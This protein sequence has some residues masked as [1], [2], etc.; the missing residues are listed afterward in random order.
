MKKHI[1]IQIPAYRDKELSKTVMDL[2]KRAKHPERLRVAIAWQH[3]RKE[4]LHK[5]V[6]AYDNVEILDIDYQDS[7][8]CNWA[9]NLLQK[10]WNGEE[11]TLFL[12]SHHRF[13]KDWD[14][15]LIAMYESL[16]S[17]GYKKPLITAY[18]PAYDPENDPEARMKYPLKIYP[19]ERDKGL[20]TKLT[21]YPIPNWK[22]LKKPFE[23]QYISLHFLFARG[24]FNKEIVFDPD[25]YF[26]GDEVLTSVRAYTH[27]Y[28]LFHP[29]VIIGWHLYDRKTRT[30]HWNDHVNWYEQEKKSFN[31]MKEIFTTYTKDCEMLLGNERSITDYET[32]IDDKLYDPIKI[33]SISI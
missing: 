1:Y 32:Y 28:D 24:S 19:L 2:M 26:F 11:Y 18:M 15:K 33:E 9:R 31:K 8:G 27:G 12:D 21:S 22:H 20:L 23:A 16:R 25:I 30:P 5:K 6:Y 7:Q 29:H 3:S 14:V 17:A 10:R 13:V 4:K